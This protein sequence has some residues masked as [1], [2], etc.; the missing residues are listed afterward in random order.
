VPPGSNLDATARFLAEHISE[1]GGQRLIVLNRA[2]AGGAI[3]A[4]AAARSPAT[5]R[6]FFSRRS[7]PW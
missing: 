4:E 3:G 5:D 6:R 1:A 7:P 2:G